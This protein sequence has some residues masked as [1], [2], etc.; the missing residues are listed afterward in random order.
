M[1]FSMKFND[2]DVNAA[3]DQIESVAIKAIRPAAQAGAQVFY[4]EVKL[5]AS[6][7]RL[8]QKTGN[9]QNSIYQVFSKDN[10]TERRA[11]YHISW[12]HIKAPHGYLIE[13]GWSRAPAHPFVR[14]AFDS[15][16]NAALQASKERYLSDVQE[17]LDRFQK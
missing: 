11:T 7:P 16:T 4:N 6:P 15:R 14:P 9:L 12:N 8:G 10:S 2:G 1:S 13:N 17:I 5:N 3:L